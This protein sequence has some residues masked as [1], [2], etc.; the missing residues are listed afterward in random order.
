[1][2][3]SGVADCKNPCKAIFA[4]VAEVQVDASSKLK[5]NKVWVAGDIGSTIINSSGADNEA[6]GAVID[7]LGQVMS[8]EIIIDGGRAMQSNFHGY[9]AVRMN[10]LLKSKCTS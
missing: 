5:V 1:L 9:P 8:Y 6:R 2:A 3:G 7:G 10:Q 4:E